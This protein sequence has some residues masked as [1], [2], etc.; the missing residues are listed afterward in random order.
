MGIWEMQVDMDIR[1]HDKLELYTKSFVAAAPE[2]SC[3][4]DLGSGKGPLNFGNMGLLSVFRTSD[5]MDPSWNPAALFVA[6]EQESFRMR[7]RRLGTNSRAVLVVP[8][9]TGEI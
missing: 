9:S 1:M 6:G 8:G 3:N 5:G 2:R 4:A 7:A